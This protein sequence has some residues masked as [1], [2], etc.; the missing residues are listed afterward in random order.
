MFSIDIA[1]FLIKNKKGSCLPGQ[2]FEK[3][4]RKTLGNENEELSYDHLPFVINEFHKPEMCKKMEFI[5]WDGELSGNVEWDLN[6]GHVVALSAAI[7]I[8]EWFEEQKWKSS[9]E[10]FGGQKF[11]LIFEKFFKLK[12]MKDNDGEGIE[13]YPA[14]G[15]VDGGI[16]S[17]G[18]LNSELYVV[19]SKAT[20]V[21]AKYVRELFGTWHLIQNSREFRKQFAPEFVSV[22]WPAEKINLIL[23][24][25]R[26]ISFK[27][28][29]K[30]NAIYQ[31]P[32][33]AFSLM[34]PWELAWYI[35]EN[36]TEEELG[37]KIYDKD[38]LSELLVTLWSITSDC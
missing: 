14:G 19:Q 37:P 17:Y 20:K 15:S 7:L 29:E 9:V 18:R 4:T 1:S 25:N 28:R 10:E 22:D 6:E 16:D 8:C 2:F 24:S 21:Q 34:G 32:Q 26:R 33:L 11:H 12:S 30:Q 36:C 38:S 3:A 27:Q 13:W 35:V 31:T 5:D 23:C